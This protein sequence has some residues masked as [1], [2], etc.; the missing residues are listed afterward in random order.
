[1]CAESSCKK[2][3]NDLDIRNLGLEKGL[4]ERYEVLSLNN[5]I[6]QMDDLGWCP[7]PGCG[8][9]A[10]IEKDLNYGKCQHCEL[11]FCLDCRQ[12][13]HPYKRCLIN[14]LDINDM[15]DEIEKK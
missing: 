3:L 8:A 15:F 1:V 13:N 14:R 11:V 4:F 6:S 5:A 12:R 7:L 9:L 10:T 2:N